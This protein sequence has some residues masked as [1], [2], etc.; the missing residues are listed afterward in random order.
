MLNSRHLTNKQVATR[1]QHTHYSPH[2][3][4]PAVVTSYL[5]FASPLQEF[6]P[7]HQEQLMTWDFKP[8]TSRPSTTPSLRAL[9]A[10]W[11]TESWSVVYIV[12]GVRLVE[13]GALKSIYNIYCKLFE[14]DDSIFLHVETTPPELMRSMQS[15]ARLS[16]YGR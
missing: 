12:A 2:E 7:P 16:S 13:V 6:T 1:A 11:T 4:Y 5:N 3:R 15:V 8:S 14:P 10:L 9:N